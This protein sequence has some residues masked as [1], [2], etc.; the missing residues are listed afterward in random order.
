MKKVVGIDIG[1]TNIRAA[2]VDAEGKILAREKTKS[3]AREGIEKLILNLKNIIR[4]AVAP[5]SGLS[6][7][8][9]RKSP[10]EEKCPCSMTSG[11]LAA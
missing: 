9:G 8:W 6:P 3:G 2:V 4:S 7:G 11:L 1:G 5:P 10:P